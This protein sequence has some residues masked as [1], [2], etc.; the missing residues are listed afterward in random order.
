MCLDKSGETVIDQ[1]VDHDAAYPLSRIET[2][3]SVQHNSSRITAKLAKKN[4]HQET[5][6]PS[7]NPGVSKTP[8]ADLTNSDSSTDDP[9]NM[10]VIG[11]NNEKIIIPAVVADI[12]SGLHNSLKKI[13]HAIGLDR[14][15]SK[16]EDSVGYKQPITSTRLDNQTQ[17]VQNAQNSDRVHNQNTKVQFQDTFTIMNNCRPN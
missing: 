7:H 3:P 17:Y 1:G 8:A 6:N 15:N 14:D 13:E 4:Q 10:E 11:P 5:D 12:F 9:E 2:D 16:S